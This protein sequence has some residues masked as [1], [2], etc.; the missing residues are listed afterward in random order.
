MLTCLP[1]VSLSLLAI[2]VSF[3]ETT[4]SLSCF[5]PS[6]CNAQKSSPLC[7]CL[8]RIISLWFPFL[9]YI[10]ST[11]F[12]LACTPSQA[13]GVFVCS[14]APSFFPIVALSLLPKLQSV[15][16]FRTRSGR[17]VISVYNSLCPFDRFKQ[18]L[19]SHYFHCCSNLLS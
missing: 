9:L 16:H 13:V 2:H 17:F 18:Y 5:S 12:L 10:F 14:L 19:F 7:I 1:S 11:S 3:S 8:H 4:L 15:D 6:I